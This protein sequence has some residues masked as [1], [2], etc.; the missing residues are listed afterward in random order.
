[1][2]TIGLLRMLDI[3]NSVAEFDEGL[4]RYFVKTQI[5][6]DF[7]SDKYDV[8]KGEK[9]V[10]K[11][12]IYK[13]VKEQQASKKLAMSDLAYS[14]GLM[15]RVHPFSEDFLIKT[16]PERMF[17]SVYGKHTFLLLFLIFL[18]M[19]VWVRKTDFLLTCC[20]RLKKM[21]C[22]IR[23]ERL[24]ACGRGFVNYLGRLFSILILVELP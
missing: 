17:F 5:Y 23:T 3:G 24:A 13:V 7:V 19:R 18:R 10:G 22:A 9:G 6:S 20:P 15:N 1:M 12:A 16:T 4:S 8:V 21:H 14:Q 11:T 2:N